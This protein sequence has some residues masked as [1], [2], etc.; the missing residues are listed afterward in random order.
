MWAINVNDFNG[1]YMIVMKADGIIE[2]LLHSSEP[3][4]NYEVARNIA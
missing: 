4:P 1:S 2:A 3:S